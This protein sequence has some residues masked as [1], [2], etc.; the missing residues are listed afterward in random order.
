[1]LVDALLP[2]TVDGSPVMQ[3][4][5]RAVAAVAVRR[6]DQL[7]RDRA[8][9]LLLLSPASPDRVGLLGHMLDDEVNPDLAADTLLDALRRAPSGGLTRPAQRDVAARLRMPVR[10]LFERLDASRRQ[11]LLRS[12]PQ[13]TP[14]LARCIVEAA[15]G[16]AFPDL[17]PIFDELLAR[18]L[19]PILTKMLRR[20]KLARERSSGSWQ[21]L[22][23]LL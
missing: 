15:G 7:G 22:L 13:L 20:Q 23:A 3:P 18:D 14:Q 10:A 11:A 21:D 4:A 12:T 9:D 19:D 5:R 2:H 16:Q 6:A 1:M 8:V 17:E